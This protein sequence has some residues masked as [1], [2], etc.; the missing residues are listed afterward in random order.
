MRAITIEIS[1]TNPLG[2]TKVAICVSKQEKIEPKINI[3][4]NN[5][6]KEK[7]QNRCPMKEKFS[8]DIMEVAAFML[9]CCHIY[10]LKF[11]LFG[12]PYYVLADKFLKSYQLCKQTAAER[13]RK[14][15]KNGCPMRANFSVNIIEVATNM[16]P[17][18]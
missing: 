10:E 2:A 9:F 13:I 6:F 4:S 7:M 8:D 11:M 14:K 17:Y 15:R 12:I 5:F 18:L 16:L 1:E 3:L